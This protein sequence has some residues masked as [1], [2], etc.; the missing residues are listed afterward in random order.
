MHDWM[1]CPQGCLHYRMC[2]WSHTPFHPTP[3]C[4]LSRRCT[5]DLPTLLVCAH[6][7]IL[8][9]PSPTHTN[10]LYHT[11]LPPP[12]PLETRPPSRPSQAAAGGTHSMALT[13]TGRTFIWG[14]AS[15]GRLGLGDNAKDHYSPVELMLP[16]G[17]ERWRVAAIAC[18]GRHT[19]CLAV[20][21]RDAPGEGAEERLDRASVPQRAAGG[22]GI[23]A[24]AAAQQ[25]QQVALNRAGSSG[26]G[27]L[28]MSPMRRPMSAGSSGEAAAAAAVGALSLS[29]AGSRAIGV[30]GSGGGGRPP[31][32]LALAQVWGT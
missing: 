21:V 29:R 11:L 5:H 13:S 30:G 22:E 12:S 24:R 6:T 19:M 10:L 3:A 28:P 17:H 23:G 1:C 18:G 20:P 15:Y 14:R 16:G 31:A 4:S 27:G 25:Q 32:A 8:Q 7:H 9:H 2:V 26:N